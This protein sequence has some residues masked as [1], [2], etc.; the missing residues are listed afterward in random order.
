MLNHAEGISFL[1]VKSQNCI[2]NGPKQCTVDTRTNFVEKNQFWF[3]HHGS[4]QL[5]EFFL[6]PGK[7]PSQL[8]CYRSQLKKI[9][10][11][12][13]PTAQFVLLRLYFSWAQPG[14]DKPLSGL[15]AW[16]YQKVF[17]NR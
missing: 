9:D 17:A 7:I 12:T 13:R 3:S 16:D 2:A 10:Y 14:V 8:V 5:Q 11:L 1:S 15:R 4:A 6:S